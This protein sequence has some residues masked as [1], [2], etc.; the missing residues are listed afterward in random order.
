VLAKYFKSAF[1]GSVQSFT[2]YAMLFLQNAVNILQKSWSRMV[3]TACLLILMYAIEAVPIF[4][5]MKIA[6]KVHKRPT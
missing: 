2:G 3:R 1:G 4:I 5:I 6:H